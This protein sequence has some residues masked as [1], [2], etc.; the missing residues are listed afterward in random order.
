LH[1]CSGFLAVAEFGLFA[2]V[3]V[4]GESQIADEGETIGDGLGLLVQSPPSWMT[5]SPGQGPLPEGFAR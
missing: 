1:E 3:K 4:R 2:V 5:I